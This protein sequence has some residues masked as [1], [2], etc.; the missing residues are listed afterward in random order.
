MS[1]KKNGKMK[2]KIENKKLQ[3]G[4]VTCENVISVAIFSI[5]ILFSGF[6]VIICWHVGRSVVWLAHGW[7][8]LVV[9]L[10]VGSRTFGLMVAG[11]LGMMGCIMGLMYY[12]WRR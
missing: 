6:L 10:E 1:G 11:T 4:K 9:W 5:I 12:K 7:F 8:G 2:N 3:I